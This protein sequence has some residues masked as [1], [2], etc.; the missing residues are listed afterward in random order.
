MMAGGLRLARYRCVWERCE[1]GARHY[2]WGWERR[3]WRQ[4][5]RSPLEPADLDHPTPFFS[6]NA[7]FHIVLDRGACCPAIAP[8]SLASAAPC[9]TASLCVSRAF[10]LLPSFFFSFPRSNIHQDHA[11]RIKADIESGLHRDTPKDVGGMA[12]KF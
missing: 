8:P 12:M 1:R 9:C 11:E 2:R 4:R 6:P 7:T 10:I 5:N 3:G